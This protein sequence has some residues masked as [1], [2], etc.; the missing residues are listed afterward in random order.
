MTVL[1]VPGTDAVDPPVDPV[2]DAWTARFSTALEAR[3]PAALA[4]CFVEDGYWRD[5]LAFDWTFRTMSG[6]KEIAGAFAA[7]LAAT[8]PHG[9]RRAVGRAAPRLVKRSGRRVIEAYFD[10]DTAVGRVSTFVRLLLDAAEPEESRAWL[11]LTAL[12]E[13]RGFAERVGDRRPTGT[14]YSRNFAGDNWLDR[15]VNTAAF[16]DREPE[17]LIV[18]GGQCGLILAARLGQI[19]V[20]ALV[21]ERNAR[22]GDNWR[23]RYHSLTLHNEVWANSMPYIPFPPT[24]PTFLPKDK[25]AGW[26]EAYAEFMEL[27]VW[28]GAEFVSGTYEDSTGRW[29]ACVRRGDEPERTFSV[30]HV[31]MATGSVSGIPHRPSL[32]GLERFTGDVIHSSEYAKG[33]RYRGAKAIVVGTGNSGHDVAQDLHSNGAAQVAMVQRSPTCVVSLVPSGTM[34]YALYSEGPDVDDIDLITAAVPYPVLRETYQWLTKKTCALDKD[35]LDGLHAAGF[36]TDFEPDGTG[37]HMRYLRYGGGYYINVGC[38][39]LISDGSV[40]LVQMRDVEEFVEI[41]LRCRDGR[42]LEADL[43]VLATG[44]ENLREGIRR[45]LGDEVAERVGHVW[46]FDEHGFMRNMWRRTPQPG[47]WLMGGALNDARLYSRFLALQ[48]KAELEGILAPSA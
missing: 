17:V 19:G 46:G 35:L 18:G 30:P 45:L 10:F 13:I 16:A 34:V 21:V 31:V 22:I 5:I 40:G 38:S 44:Y 1:N 41:G 36:E 2:V 24:W 33:R 7:G 11:M 26:L 12:Q 39:E 4:E 29:Q 6:R 15:R 20:D 14:E 27:N 25:L 28:T 3:D 8:Q 43:V 42:V 48:I 47:L 32:P 37:F 23:Q 9:V